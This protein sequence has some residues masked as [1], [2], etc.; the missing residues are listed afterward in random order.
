VSEDWAGVARAISQRMAELD[1]SQ[2]QLIERSRVS[3]ATVGEL[4]RNSA[5]RR[6]STRTLEA[7][8]TAL[9]WHPTHL[10]AVL[11]G[12]RIPDA[13]EPHHA[14]DDIP[15][16]LASIE[17][18]LAEITARLSAV[19]EFNGRLDD[20]RADVKTAIQLISGNHR[21]GGR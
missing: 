13:G 16:R 5:Q 12:R 8:S 9:G 4:V 20:I 11:T 19:D 1:L 15:G 18:M 14:D 17:K 7:L 10:H 21:N 6:R 3:K 2:R